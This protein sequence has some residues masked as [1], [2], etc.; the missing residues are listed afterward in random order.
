MLASYHG[1]APTVTLLLSFGADP[2]VLN[3]RG[4]SPIA[5]AVF[6][7]YEDVVRVLFEGG[8]DVLAGHPT[9]V[10]CARMFQRGGMCEL[11]GVEMGDG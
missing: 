10:D 2:N 5:G 3:D 9:A 6:K 11:F 7:G 8:A 1:H 4:Q